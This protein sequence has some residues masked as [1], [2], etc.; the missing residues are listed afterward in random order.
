MEDDAMEVASVS[1][2]VIG[3]PFLSYVM[4]EGTGKETSV[5]RHYPV[6]VHAVEARASSQPAWQAPVSASS[7]AGVLPKTFGFHVFLL[8]VVCV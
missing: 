2:L 5:R 1:M 6:H 4:L 8:P 3:V 7:K